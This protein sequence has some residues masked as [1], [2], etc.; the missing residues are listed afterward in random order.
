MLLAVRR[1]AQRCCEGS[2]QGSELV[3]VYTRR[4]AHPP[5]TN[6]VDKEPS[7]LLQ[8]LRGARV[9]FIF[10]SVEADPNKKTIRNVD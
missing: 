3:F 6:H 8:H 1:A 10:C 9:A 2:C 5:L 7:A 4:P